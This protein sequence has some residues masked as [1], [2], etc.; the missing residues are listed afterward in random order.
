MEV[1]KNL[2]ITNKRDNVRFYLIIGTDEIPL[3]NEGIKQIITDFLKDVRFAYINFLPNVIL[4]RDKKFFK[5]SIKNA[6]GDVVNL[7]KE[8]LSNNLSKY[9]PKDYI[10]LELE[11]KKIKL[12]YKK[13]FIATSILYSVA[14]DVVENLKEGKTVAIKN[15]QYLARV[16]PNKK[17]PYDK[18]FLQVIKE[19]KIE[20]DKKNYVKI[21]IT[22]SAFKNALIKAEFKM[23][24]SGKDYAVNNS[25]YQ[26]L[27]RIYNKEYKVAYIGIGYKEKQ[28]AFIVISYK[29][30][31]ETE[32]NQSK[33]KVMGVDLGQ[34]NLVYYAIRDGQSRG[35]VSLSYSWE[36]KIRGIW[37]RKKHLQKSLMEIKNLKIKDQATEKTYKKTVEELKSL[38]EYEKNFM[39]TLNKQ[40]ASKLITIAVKEG[41]KTIVLEDLSLSPDEKNA[42]AFPKWNYYQLQTFIENKAK[43]NG[44]EVKKINPAFTSQRCPNCGFIGYYKE[45]VRPKRE[46]FTC[47]VCNYSENADY[48]GALNIATGSI[49]EKIKNRLKS[50][51]EKL[52][53]EK[54]ADLS[55]FRLF[56]MRNKL[57]KEL[58]KQ[59]LNLK[60]DNLRKLLKTLEIKNKDAYNMLLKDLKQFKVEYLDKRIS[61]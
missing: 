47:P 38:R 14:K 42:L 21:S 41:V 32:N 2:K 5:A 53:N 23:K 49:E 26:I 1:N 15:L 35:D 48:V 8:N 40:V 46:R 50:D 37:N 56:A 51:V 7:S 28:G 45:M 10:E 22:F 29:F 12:E 59:F 30:E 27:S 6:K 13:D 3:K 4:Q 60:T 34:V 52:T 61:Q 11:G 33:V 9:I 39:E 18:A 20:P 25:Y 24:L 44:I 54:I 58:L 17:T 16:K 36:D 43:E 19:F 55:V 31:K 57:V